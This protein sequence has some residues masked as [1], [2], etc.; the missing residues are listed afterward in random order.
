MRVMSQITD[1]SFRVFQ[2]TSQKSRLTAAFFAIVEI[3]SWLN[4]GVFDPYRPELH[5]M[6]GPGPKWREKHAREAQPAAVE[7]AASAAALPIGDYSHAVNSP[8]RFSPL[9]TTLRPHTS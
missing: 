8:F 7:Q 3:W 6:R 5:Y 1:S 2:S 9:L 4:K